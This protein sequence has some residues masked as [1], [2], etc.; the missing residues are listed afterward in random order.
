MIK[1]TIIFCFVLLLMACEDE[2]VNRGDFVP[3]YFQLDSFILLQDSLLQAHGLEKTVQLNEKREELKSDGNVDWLGELDFFTKADINSPA[4]AAAYSEEKKGDSIV[5]RLKK[6][7]KNKVKTLTVRL[8]DDERPRSISFIM[9]K[10]NIFYHSE[11]KGDMQIDANTGLVSAY[12]ISG[13]QKVVFLSPLDMK[14]DAKVS[15]D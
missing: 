8:Y 13:K 11:T 9:E 1:K 14:V 10:D 12:Q 2:Q 6:G 15:K 4:L 3:P 5:Y 7:E